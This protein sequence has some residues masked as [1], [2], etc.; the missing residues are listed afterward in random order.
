[1]VSARRKSSK[2]IS[3]SSIL[4]HQRYFLRLRSRPWS[5]CATFARKSSQE[6]IIWMLIREPIQIWGRMTARSVER[7]LCEGRI[8]R[9]MWRS[10]IQEMVLRSERAHKTH[11]SRQIGT[12]RK[13]IEVLTTPPSRRGQFPVVTWWVEPNVQ[14]DDC[15]RPGW[16]HRT[17]HKSQTPLRLF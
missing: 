11:L 1:M 14:A 10:C 3:T 5:T 9:D 16:N 2:N 4:I 6:L 15:T 8:G 12:F 13:G 7:L 17:I